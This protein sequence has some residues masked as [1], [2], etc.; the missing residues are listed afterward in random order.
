VRTPPASHPNAAELKD[1][2]LNTPH[3]TA[4][5]TDHVGH[6]QYD[7]GLRVASSG[8]LRSASPQSTNVTASDVVVEAERPKEGVR[9]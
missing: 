1:Q 7:M 3:S 8:S 9:V 2:S 6:L 4:P 5:G